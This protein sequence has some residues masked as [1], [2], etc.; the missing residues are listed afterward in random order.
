[1]KIAGKVVVV[2]GAACGIGAA[3]AARFAD[4]EPLGLVVSDIDQDGVELVARRL[5]ES[6]AGVL[7]VPADVTDRAAAENVI[8]VTEREFGAVDLLCSNVGIA[9]GMGVHAPV[10]IW[11]RAWSVNVLGHVHLAQAVLPGMSRRRQGHI[12]ITASAA[13]LLGIPGDAP[14]AVTKSAAVAFAEWLAVTY[15]RAGVTVSALCPLGV[16]T[17]LL[18]P[19]VAAGHRSA[20]AVAE[21][22][23]ILEPADVADAVVAGIAE[24]RFLILPHREVGPLYAGKAADPDA[25]IHRNASPGRA[26]GRDL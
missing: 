22:G 21:L 12:V 11:E 1:M 24:E 20:R 10:A 2:T 4:E 7:A 17:D 26:R 8:A 5:R 14:Y 9:T 23:P 16:R 19:A 13:G 6:G 3:L 15:K 18:M 25:W